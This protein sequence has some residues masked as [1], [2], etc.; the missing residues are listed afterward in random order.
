MQVEHSPGKMY[1]FQVTAV[2]MGLLNNQQREYYYNME[3]LVV[4]QWHHYT[5][6]RMGLTLMF[7]L[8]LLAV[9]MAIRQFRH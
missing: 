7:F 5:V 4:P 8:V 3:Q 9:Y 6:N 2:P 1:Y